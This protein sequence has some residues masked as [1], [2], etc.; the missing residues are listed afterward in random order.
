MS[1]EIEPDH[2]ELP[3]VDCSGCGACCLH[4]G[5]PSYVTASDGQ[6]AEEPWLNM[7]D[8]LKA[9]LLQQM[10]SYVRPLSGELDGICCWYDAQ[11]QRCKHHEHRPNVCR[12]FQI[13][14]QDCLGWRDVYF[15]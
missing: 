9:E 3:V 2:A 6:A 7:P 11:L 14:S 13:G 4:M 8:D 1:L 15:R 10:E 5:F 12:D